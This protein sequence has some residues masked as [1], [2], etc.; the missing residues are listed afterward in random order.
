V[1]EK[2]CGLKLEERKQAMTI[3][4]IHHVE[5]VPTDN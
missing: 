3:V 4:V 1:L 5:R 2:Q